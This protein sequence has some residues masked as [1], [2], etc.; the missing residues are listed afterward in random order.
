M[1][2]KDRTVI[3]YPDRALVADLLDVVVP[4]DSQ[5]G[6]TEAGL[7]GWLDSL[8]DRDHAMYWAELFT[9]GLEA[10]S[11]ELETGAELVAELGAA[12]TRPGWSV[13]PA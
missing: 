8:A 6:A 12:Q 1:T 9:P 5:P 2:E 10:L 7:L 13:S 4:A 11:G 3:P